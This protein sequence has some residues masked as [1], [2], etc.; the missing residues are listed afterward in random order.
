[1]VDYTLCK[2]NKCPIKKACFRYMVS[3][4]TYQSYFT[5]T[6]YDIKDNKC[7]YFIRMNAVK[8]EDIMENKAVK[9][10]ERVTNLIYNLGVNRATFEKALFLVGKRN[11]FGFDT[12]KS[13][14]TEI[15]PEACEYKPPVIMSLLMEDTCQS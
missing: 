6:P 15:S 2:D 1:M 8:S 10:A 12:T 13:D 5:E 3:P 9:M 11:V 4:G 7:E 14:G